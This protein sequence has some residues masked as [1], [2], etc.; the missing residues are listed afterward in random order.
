M[1]SLAQILSRHRSMVKNPITSGNDV[2]DYIVYACFFL[3]FIAR[4]TVVDPRDFEGYALSGRTAVTEKEY[5][6]A[7]QYYK[8]AIARDAFGEVKRSC[9][10]AITQKLRSAD[11]GYYSIAVGIVSLYGRP[12]TNND[13][14]GPLSTKKVP[15]KFK[16]LHSYLW[17]LRNKAFSHSE[18][19]AQL[20]GHGKMT[21]VRFIFDGQYFN[22]FS[23]RPIFE[24]VMLP[25]I[26]DLAD[27]LETDV[28]QELEK[29]FE[30]FMKAMMLTLLK[31][32][33][34]QEFELNVENENGPMII[35]AADSIANK[36]PVVRPISDI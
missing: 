4:W 26:R 27:I 6:D 12:F 14:I 16:D 36:Y 30:K 3:F 9:D 13:R 34:G 24:P 22:S 10:Y 8:L 23:S 32:G 29:L 1:R 28:E 15:K 20:P 2:S 19:G 11:P 5:R 33:A 18:A 7:R 25:S 31:T 21:E 35:K 17:E